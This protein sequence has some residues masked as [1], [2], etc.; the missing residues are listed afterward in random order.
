MDLNWP[1][2]LGQVG[3]ASA[4]L[5]LRSVTPSEGAQTGTSERVIVSGEEMA[6][7]ADQGPEAGKGGRFS[8]QAF[9]AL[10]LVA[11]VHALLL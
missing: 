11:N 9:R 1:L 6:E 8:S 4:I 10:W 2:R 7:G 5:R 3:A